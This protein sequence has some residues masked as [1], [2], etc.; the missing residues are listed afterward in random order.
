M[1]ESVQAQVRADLV[2]R[3]RLGAERYGTALYPRNGRDALL[4]AY[5][6]ALDLACYLKQALLERDE[7][8]RKDRGVDERGDV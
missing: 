8:A 4:D 5:E 3:E 2:E 6:E 7:H 1:T